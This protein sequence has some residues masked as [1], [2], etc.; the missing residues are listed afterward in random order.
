[1]PHG[2]AEVRW[3]LP[4]TQVI[5]ILPDHVY[6]LVQP[7]SEEVPGPLHDHVSSIHVPLLNRSRRRLPLLGRPAG[8]VHLTS[9]ARPLP[10]GHRR[11]FAFREARVREWGTLGGC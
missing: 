6:D 7:I 4:A 1:P 2:G 8:G 10:E 5:A 9:P 3:L 11:T